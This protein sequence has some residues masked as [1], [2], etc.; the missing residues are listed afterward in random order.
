M[1]QRGGDVEDD[2]HD[3]EPEEAPAKALPF[4][5]R[6][7]MMHV[8]PAPALPTMGLAPSRPDPAKPAMLSAPKVEV[9]KPAGASTPPRAEPAKVD[10][11]SKP[12]PAELPPGFDPKDVPVAEYGAISAELMI[13]RGERAKVLETH[14]LSEPAWARIHAHWTAEMGRETAR[15]ESKL[16]AQ[17]DAAYVET[18][19]RLRK[20]I[21]VPEYALILVAIERGAIDK[22]LAAFSLTLSDL[23]RVQRVWT[24]RLAEDPELGKVLGKAVEEARA[25]VT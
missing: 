21:G 5:E 8:P 2:T 14:H 4:V 3:R 7:A 22:Q 12:P 25:A 10:G 16:L 9:V 18:M 11:K 1:L 6:P 20:P 19:G 24:R 15:G 17:F 13:R 23:M